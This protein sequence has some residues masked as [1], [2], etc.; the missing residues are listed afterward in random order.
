MEKFFRAARPTR[1]TRLGLRYINLLDEDLF[2]ASWPYSLALGVPEQLKDEVLQQNLRV[3]Y[4]DAHSGGT[5]SVGIALPA[6]LANGRRGSLLDLDCANE[7]PPQ[8]PLDVIAWARKAHDSIYQVFR[9]Y[10]EPVYGRLKER[11]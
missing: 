9:A 11:G 6:Q 3:S 5:L 4:R 2:G 8:D 1:V 7:E 10:I